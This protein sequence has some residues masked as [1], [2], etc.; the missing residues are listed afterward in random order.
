MAKM[1]KPN[2]GLDFLAKQNIKQ[3]MLKT[4]TIYSFMKKR[5]YVMIMITQK[6]VLHTQ[7][8]KKKKV[9]ITTME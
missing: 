3:K 5:L 8:K 2:K 7:Q 4:P 9:C 6:Y 1:A